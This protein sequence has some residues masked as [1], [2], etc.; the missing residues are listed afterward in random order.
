[1]TNQTETD[2]AEAGRG[3]YVP[4]GFLVFL[5]ALFVGQFSISD[6]MQ[7][8]ASQVFQSAEA[9]A[10]DSGKQPDA[11]G[12]QPQPL[13]AAGGIAGNELWFPTGQAERRI[14]KAKTGLAEGD[15]AGKVALP[16]SGALIYPF[17]RH[18]VRTAPDIADAACG[19]TCAAAF[20]SRAP[21]VLGA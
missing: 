9:A 21:P 7:Q 4:F 17:D 10:R 1:M 13:S 3:L 15:A 20:N 14:A 6:G 5:V 11:S 16:A 19:K 12:E 2:R 8:A 18:A